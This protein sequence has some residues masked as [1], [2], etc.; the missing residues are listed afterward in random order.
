MPISIFICNDN[1]TGVVDVYMVF[2]AHASFFLQRLQHVLSL[3]IYSNS[4]TEIKKY[5]RICRD[6]THVIAASNWAFSSPLT[7]S[8]R[9][10]APSF[11][12][13]SFS[14]RSMQK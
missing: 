5:V 11:A 2:K 6:V 14:S 3:Y 13:T 8:N 1:H 7:M 12:S 10:S 4:V 9:L